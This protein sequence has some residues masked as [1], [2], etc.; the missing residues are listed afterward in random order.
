MESTV[1]ANADELVIVRTFAAPPALV[2]AAWTD[3]RQLS[4]WI[5]PH[6]FSARNERLELRPGGAWHATLRAP[7]GS[8]HRIRGIYR[9]IE[10]PRRLVFSHA[11]EDGEG[12]LSP[13]TLVTV[14]FAEDGPGR[15]RMHFRQTGFATPEARDAHDEGWSAS[16]E[17]LTGALAGAAA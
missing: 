2:F 10:A 14:T 16:F 8:E 1:T 4:R 3:P 13:Q 17:R 5:G 9:E 6:G 11:W 7:D 15:T 12:R